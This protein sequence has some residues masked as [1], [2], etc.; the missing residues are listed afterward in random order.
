[1]RLV[2]KIFVFLISVN[3]AG[4]FLYAQ[5]RTITGRVSNA[6]G[7]ALPFS[8][9]IL[10]SLPD[11]AFLAHTT[12]NTNGYFTIRH[13]REGNAILQIRH[14]GYITQ[15]KQ[16]FLDETNHV[17]NFTL[18]TSAIELGSISI[19]ARM[20]GARISGDTIIFNLGAYTD[21]TER[22]L[23][24]ILRNLPGVEIGESG[25]VYSEGQPIRVLVDGREFF[26]DQ[27]Q[28]ATRNLPA[29]M[30][31]GVQLIHNHQEIGM[32]RGS[33][34]AQGITVLNISIKE[35]YRNRPS[36]VL[37][38]G[39]GV[40]SKY[41]GKANL[42][43][44]SNNLS[45]ATLLS[46]NNT[47]EMA[48]TLEDF[49]RFQGIRRLLSSSRGGNRFALGAIDVP[50][51]SFREDVERRVGQT[52]AFNLSYQ[53]PNNQLQINSYLIA[54]RQEQH[55]KTLSERWA[56][57]NI[58]ETP[59]SMDT[60][61]EQ[62]R[63]NFV[64]AYIGVDYQPT[65]RF[66][67]SNR[68]MVSWQNTELSNR[69]SRQ[70]LTLSDS[71]TVG[72]NT[73][74]FNFRNY[75]LAMYQTENY[76]FFTFDGF[77]RYSHRPNTLNLMS[78]RMFM[79]LPFSALGNEFV[80]FQD[81]SQTVREASFFVDYSHGLGSF[82]LT[83][84]IGMSFL[85]Q[86]LNTA[87]F[88]RIDGINS[89]FLPKQDYANSLRYS[90]TNVWAGLWLERNL[91]IFR[92]SLGADV[93]YFRTNLNQKNQDT[94]VENNQWKI[95]PSA[96]IL[97]QLSANH[98]L[99]FSFNLAEDARNAV[100]LNDSWVIR[101][102]QSITHGKVVEDLRSPSFRLSASYSHINFHSGT[103]LMFNSSYTRHSQPLTLNH[104][105]HLGYSKVT[106]VESPS[107]SDFMTTLRF[108]QSLPWFP[109]DVRMSATY[110][111]GS[112]YTFINHE[113]NAITQ[114][115][116]MADLGL[117]SFRRTA[118]LNGELG[119]RLMWLQNESRLMDRTMQLLTL[120]PY[121]RLRANFGNG[122]TVRA[123]A[124]HARYNTND[125]Q[126]HVTNL[127]SSIVYIPPRSRFEFELRANN[128]LNF[129]QTERITS[130]ISQSFF[131]ERVIRTL[132]GYLMLKISFR[133]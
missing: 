121:L 27:S 63:F 36:G 57:N 109:V 46:A 19:N 60:H 93:Q 18:E 129:N 81:N 15:G 10:M 92:L 78:N 13:N 68:S 69:I 110:R 108:R 106:V 75:L 83:P 67:I 89:P 50:T 55:G 85:Q 65:D 41:S 90:N 59:F 28:M 51:Q 16:L 70:L 42:F 52:G 97:V 103:T 20:L 29:G 43:N 127:S 88:Q 66:F 107:R 22:V 3:V 58:G 44:F 125:M 7:Q 98:R 74:G 133:I 124:E 71:L 116:A 114:T 64:N 34:Q 117:I 99:N 37:M 6:D 101:N 91:G 94:L 119:G 47:G 33:G 61:S 9:V 84:Q 112:S 2:L 14:L 62:N 23:G 4:G 21:G 54:N 24:D 72:E 38:A 131:E 39:G 102:F 96:R 49:V 40:M 118:I 115:M 132:P 87:L 120:T 77:F 45:L 32:L 48:F 53:H 100:D 82:F 76:N 30:V 11:S 113:K 25:R 8:T 128:I 79:D 130:L 17:V 126:R 1:M 73:T 12:T 95:L 35:E 26:L 86:D 122:W 5:E 80:A 123:S 105:F 111:L 56:L 31:G 104:S